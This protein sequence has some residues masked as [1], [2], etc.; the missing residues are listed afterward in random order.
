MN[1]VHAEVDAHSRAKAARAIWIGR[2]RYTLIHELQ[3]KLVLARMEGRIQDTILLLE[4]DAVV[5]LGRNAKRENV[6][7]TAESLARAG[8][9][10]VQT[11][12]GGDVTYHGPGQ[13]VAYPILDLAPDRCDV[14]RYVRALAETMILLLREHG[15]EAGVAS[16]M[17]GVWADKKAPGLWGG[18]PWA[19]EIAKV[20]AIGVR[21]SR[22]VTMHGFALNLNVDLRDFQCIVPCGIADHAVTSLLELTSRSPSVREAAA[23]LAPHLARALGIAVSPVEDLETASDDELSTLTLAVPGARETSNLVQPARDAGH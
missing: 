20:G 5:T 8:V 9:D 19:S 18:E 23:S 4:H 17:I 3:E 14:R 15:V 13:L 10:L 6:L 1:P 12:R 21:L 2:R 7:F 16:G 22:W 11:A